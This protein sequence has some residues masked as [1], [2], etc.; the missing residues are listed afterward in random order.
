MINL[1][2]QHAK[3]AQRIEY[4]LRIGVVA[5]VLLFYLMVIAAFVFA[6]A[7]YTLHLKV[8]N[9]Q[10]SLEARER[11]VSSEVEDAQ[12]SLADVKAQVE[13][14]KGGVTDMPPTKAISLIASKRFPGIALS[15]ISYEDIPGARTAQVRGFSDTRDALTF[16]RKNLREDE[17]F[18]DAELP[19]NVFIKETDLDF[20][21]RINLK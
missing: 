14:L 8:R 9:L 20:S 4:R 12:T 3:R 10:S 18:K 7:Y 17:H 1:L 6:P 19:A 21:M 11:A 15:S 5:S 16:F 13:I 2:P